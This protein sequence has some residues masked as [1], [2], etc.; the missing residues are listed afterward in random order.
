MK[1]DARARYTLKIIRE[2][3]IG[4]LK[5]KSVNKVTVKEL[6]EKAEINRATFY[7]YY[8]DIFDLYEKTKEEFTK[9]LFG[10]IEMAELTNIEKDIVYFLSAMRENSDAVY[11]F[12]RQSD[13]HKFMKNICEKIYNGFDDKIKELCLGLNERE[14]QGTY[15]YVVCGSTGII[16]EWVKR[17]MQSDEKEIAFLLSKLIT[18]TLIHL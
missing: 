14:R 12:A 1:I 2:T 17:G 3:F 13:A 10:K 18:N 15:Y 16:G 5:E 6:C 7:R 8:E 9:E 11:A 4:L